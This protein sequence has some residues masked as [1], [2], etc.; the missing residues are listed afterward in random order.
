MDEA[1]KLREE[2]NKNIAPN[3]L[4]LNDLIIKAASLA[5]V[6]VPETNS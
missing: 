3:K 5:C 2:L 4:S 1:L 6:A